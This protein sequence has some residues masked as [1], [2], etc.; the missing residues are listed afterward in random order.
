MDTVIFLAKPCQTSHIA[1]SLLESLWEEHKIVC[2]Y[3]HINKKRY[4]RYPEKYDLGISFLY[5][6]LVPQ[7]QVEQHI[8][9]NFHCGDLPKH[10]GRN[11]GYRTV[12]DNSTSFGGTLHWMNEYF[13]KGR[14]VE[15]KEFIVNEDD[16]AKDIMQKSYEQL[17]YLFYKYIPQII[18]GNFPSGKQND[19]QYIKSPKIDDYIELTEYQ[20]KRIRALY[21]PPFYPH[22][23]IGNKNYKIIEEK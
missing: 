6:Y 9:F 18:N 7:E 11:L 22:I 1:Y 14:I 20:Q 16:T 19:S 8:W 23:K 4:K 10:P 12:M 15:V 21:C 13:D 2:L 17:I 3:K 5:P